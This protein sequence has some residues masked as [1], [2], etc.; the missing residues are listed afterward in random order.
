[1][2]TSTKGIIAAGLL[3]AGLATFLFRRPRSRRDLMR[4]SARRLAKGA[5][6]WLARQLET[7]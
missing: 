2:N 1:M 5:A 6:G 4:K 3:A 7:V